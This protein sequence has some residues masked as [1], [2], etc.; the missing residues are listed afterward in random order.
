MFMNALSLKQSGCHT[1][2]CAGSFCIATDGRPYHGTG[3]VTTDASYCSDAYTD[4]GKVQ[5]LSTGCKFI[6]K[7]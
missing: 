6:I 5:P 2:Q 4:D 3:L 7:H 1:Y